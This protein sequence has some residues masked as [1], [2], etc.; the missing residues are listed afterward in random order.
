VDVITVGAP[1]A[2]RRGERLRAAAADLPERMRRAVQA[3]TIIIQGRLRR[4]ELRGSKGSHPFWGVTGARGSALGV[5][6]G[7]TTRSIVARVTR[8]FN[9]V[10]GTV[11]SPLAHMRPHERGMTIHGKPWLRIPTA[12]AQ[13]GAGVDRY[14]GRSARDIPGAFLLKSRAGN[15]WIALRTAGGTLQLLYLLKRV[16]RLRERAPMRT[17]LHAVRP[18]LRALFRRLRVDLQASLRV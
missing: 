5:R 8:T 7:M 14:A 15:L 4:V 12:A 1:N 18:E 13:T 16:V 11:G 3:G 9:T 6:S 10:I 17:A 2:A